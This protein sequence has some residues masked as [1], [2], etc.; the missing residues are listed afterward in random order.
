M[1]FRFCIAFILLSNFCNSQDTLNRVDKLNCKFGY[2]KVYKDI[3]GRKMLTEE[4][5]YNN[6]RKS[7]LWI[8]YYKDGFVKSKINFID[9]RPDGKYII[10][11]NNG[12]VK[13]EGIW[14]KNQNSGKR[15]T[16]YESG[17]VKSIFDNSKI[18]IEGIKQTEYFEN[19]NIKLE[20]W[21]DTL[22]IR[23]YKNGNRKSLSRYKERKTDGEQITCF[24]T[25]E[26]ATI[27]NYKSGIRHG[28]FALYHRNGKMAYTGEYKEE[29][30][31]GQ[32]VCY[33]EKGFP[34]NGKFTMSDISGKITHEGQ[35]VNGLLEGIMIVYSPNGDKS[36]EVNFR[37]GKPNGLTHYFHKGKKYK[38]ETYKDGVFVSEVRLKN[39]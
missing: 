10:F 15:I 5:S 4:G 7:G 1:Y 18:G 12:I 27:V 13:E 29:K 32:R 38:T 39:D 2:W 11:Y 21:L 14:K 36:M 16:Y 17:K 26:I 23:Y 22:E 3:D 8:E 37:D 19:G 33:D 34:S 30:M 25:E 9:G 6:N 31:F 24:E 20:L 35:C 28:K